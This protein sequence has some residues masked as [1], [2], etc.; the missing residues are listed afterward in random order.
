MRFLSHACILV[1]LAAAASIAALWV[2]GNSLELHGSLRHAVAYRMPVRTTTALDGD[3]DGI[4][5]RVHQLAGLVLLECAAD[6]LHG[7]RQVEHAHS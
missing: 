5:C 2:D 4:A 1:F 3:G 6:R 7:P